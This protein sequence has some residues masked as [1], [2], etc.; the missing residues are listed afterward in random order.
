MACHGPTSLLHPDP[1]RTPRLPRPTSGGAASGWSATPPAPR[2]GRVYGLPAPGRPPGGPATALT[3]A[4][5]RPCAACRG[6]TADR[7]HTPPD[8]P[9]PLGAPGSRRADPAPARGSVERCDTA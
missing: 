6:G 3:P 8:G 9:G 5:L 4:E 7:R 1:E 2:P